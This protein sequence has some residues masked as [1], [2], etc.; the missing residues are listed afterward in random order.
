MTVNV[1]PGQSKQLSERSV[2]TGSRKC[3]STKQMKTWSNDA[4][5]NPRADTVAGQGSANAIYGRPLYGRNIRLTLTKE[6]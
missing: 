4:A 2:A 1:P 5:G 6:W 3:S